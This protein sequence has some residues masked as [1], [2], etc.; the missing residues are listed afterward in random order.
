MERFRTA[1]GRTLS[2]RVEGTGPKLVCHP[3]GPGF[4]SRYFGD[5]AGLGEEFTL[6]LLDPRGTGGSDRPADARAYRT[7][8]YVSDLEEL[9]DHLELDR[10]LL[11][12][13]SHGGVVAAAYAAAYPERVER[14][15]L[16]SALARFAEKHQQAMAE[17]AEARSHEPW[18]EDARE[19]LEREEA[20]DFADDD[21]LQQLVAREMPFYFARYGDEERRYVE[22]LG[23]ERP[24]KD[25]LHLFNTE[26]WNTFDLLQDLTKITAATLVITGELDFITGPVCAADF[27]AIP[28]QRTV[29][30]EGC[31]HF[32]LFE[33]RD[34]FRDEVTAFLSAGR[35]D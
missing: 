10:L 8:D 14:L 5:L 34:R 4:S 19:A 31:G 17:A 30:F 11:L 27:A 18:Y 35:G 12:G 2:Y 29:P 13:H 3:G 1:D 26:V 24:N 21:E 16:A 25:A 32:I 23:E 9:R 15:V 22:W 7:E 33:A 28:D 6:V 20:G